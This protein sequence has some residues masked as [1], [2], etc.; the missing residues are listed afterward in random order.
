MQV[1]SA[2]QTISYNRL[3]ATLTD[4][5]FTK[6]FLMTFKS[7]MTVEDLFNMLIERY[8]IPEPQG[9]NEEE[10]SEW[11]SKKQ[12]VIKARYARSCYESARIC[13]K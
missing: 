11:A 4:A 5:T 10:L 12:H 2:V 9:L 1:R 7:F 13:S 6:D 3:S 8:E